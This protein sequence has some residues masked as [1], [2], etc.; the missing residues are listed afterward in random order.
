MK[1]GK[2]ALHEALKRQILTLELPPD[3]DLDE[4]RFSEEYGI[5]RTPV[6][7]SWRA[8]ATSR[9]TVPAT[10][11]SARTRRRTSPSTSPTSW[12]R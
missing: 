10:S 7:G 6:R 1:G 8:R 11:P 12:T 3:R 9:S 2:T 5:S 4:V